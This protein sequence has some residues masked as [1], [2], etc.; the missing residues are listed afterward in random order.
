MARFARVVLVDEPYHVTHRG[1]HRAA[2]FFGD[3]DRDV[4]L[5][6]LAE[7]C[8]KY[9]LDV[10]AYCLMSNHVHLIA[11][12]RAG[13]ALAGGIGRTHM[14]YSRWINKDRGWTGHHWANRFHSSL[15]DGEHLL[16]AV[17]YVEQNPVRAGLVG[18]CEDW[19]WS[20]ARAH[21]GLLNRPDPVLSPQRPFP[22]A[23]PGQSWI[24]W[25]NEGLQPQ[26]CELLR[27]NT[28]TGRPTV[29][30]ESLRRVEAVLNREL[31]PNK[32]GRPPKKSADLDVTEDLFA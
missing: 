22:S 20:S 17:R 12:P 19:P 18:R 32:R 5:A 14:R 30:P 10:W 16:N 1:N 13:P 23:A 21:A 26:F 2:V 31:A 29:T 7:A 27:A 3:D 6:M 11:V 28:A 9:Q 15:L 24:E 25:V 4:Y 8:R